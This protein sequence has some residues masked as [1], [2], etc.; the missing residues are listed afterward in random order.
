MIDII[1]WFFL[2]YIAFKVFTRFLFPYLLKHYLTKYQQKFYQ[3]NADVDPNRKE[4]DTNVD[5]VPE[6][7]SK[8][9]KNTENLGEYI[10][11]EEI[12]NK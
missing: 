3:Q 2:I 6:N 12:D 1:L 4:G 7:K 8:K 9:N 11:Y 10:D 5:F